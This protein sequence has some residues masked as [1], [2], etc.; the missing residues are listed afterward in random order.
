MADRSADSRQPLS[1]EEIQKYHE[2][3]VS[4]LRYYFTEA[5]SSFARFFDS[6]PQELVVELRRRLEETDFRSILVT[7]AALEASFRIDYQSRCRERLKDDLSRALRAIYKEKEIHVSLDQDIFEAW[8]DH[9]PESKGMIG[10]LRAAFRLRH[11]LAHGR[12]WEPRI[13]RNF[14]FDSVFD[15][16]VAVNQDLFG[17]GSVAP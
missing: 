2:D 14:D 15:L 16:A 9:F 1:L 17:G 5:P 12:Y 7:L 11:W 8:K 13:G 6:T 4:S 3:A 10:E